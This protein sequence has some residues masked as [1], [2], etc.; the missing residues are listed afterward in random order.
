MKL[1]VLDKK[2]KWG[3]H[4]AK[5]YEESLEL[6][7][8][9][10]EGD[11]AHIAEEALD[12]IQVTIGVLDKLHNEGMDIQQAIYRH[13]KKLVNRGWKEKAIVKIQVNKG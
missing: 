6:V 4:K 3:M 7:E 5:V 2:E 11:N 12:V 9:I 10:K 13:N 1:M 8:A